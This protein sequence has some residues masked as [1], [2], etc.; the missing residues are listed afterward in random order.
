MGNTLL[1]AAGHKNGLA[2]RRGRITY[3]SGARWQG[4]GTP[5][6]ADD[7]RNDQKGQEQ[8]EQNLRDSCRGTSDAA[9][10]K[11]TRDK[12]DNEEDKCVVEHVTL[13]FEVVG[14]T[15]FLGMPGS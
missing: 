7:Q 8:E 12:G 6:E 4:S 5:E 2:V 10:A 3:V 14:L 13:L 1:E 15:T 9:K 11:H